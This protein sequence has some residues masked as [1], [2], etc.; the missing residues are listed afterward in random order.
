ML[1]EL[2]HLGSAAELLFLEEMIG[3][4][5]RLKREDGERKEKEGRRGGGGA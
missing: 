3:V 1:S 4:G 5:L 2:A